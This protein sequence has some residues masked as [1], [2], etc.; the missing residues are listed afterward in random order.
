M[1]NQLAN[2]VVTKVYLAGPISLGGIATEEQIASFM[3]TFSYNC[4]ALRN[5]GF[6]V[7]NPCELTKRDSWEEYMKATLPMVCES[8]VVAIQHQWERSRGSRLE[9]FIALELGIP[10]M[11]VEELITTQ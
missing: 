2:H 8:N 4:A 10:V 7:L 5:L 6:D 3:R 9:V 1:V 11:K